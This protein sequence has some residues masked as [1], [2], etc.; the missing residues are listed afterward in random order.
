MGAL[1]RER[2]AEE[3]ADR[4]GILVWRSIG[5]ELEPR[6]NPTGV[7]A[8]I[9]RADLIRVRRDEVVIE[10]RIEVFDDRHACR[11]RRPGE[12]MLENA[13]G[14]CRAQERTGSVDRKIPDVE[15]R[16]TGIDRRPARRG[17]GAPEHTLLR[18]GIKP[19]RCAWIDR[20]RHDYHRTVQSVLRSDP[21]LAAVDALEYAAVAQPNDV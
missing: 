13:G 12:P 20:Q 3:A 21:R 10:C 19:R 16:Q 11:G 6:A 7:Y 4:C 2:F 14:G 5:I 9:E 18:S 15:T 1:W 17:V 8:I